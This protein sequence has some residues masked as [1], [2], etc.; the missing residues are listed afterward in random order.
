MFIFLK[1]TQKDGFF[2]T[3]HHIF[4]GGKFCTQEGIRIFKKTFLAKLLYFLCTITINSAYQMER[5]G[6]PYYTDLAFVM[7]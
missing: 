6:G 2:D 5:I 3:H 4:L 7:I 1:S